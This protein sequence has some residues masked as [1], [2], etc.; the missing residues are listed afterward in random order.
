MVGYA[1]TIGTNTSVYYNSG[2][3][4]KAV[5]YVRYG[6]ESGISGKSS[7]ELKKKET[8]QGWDFDNIWG[9]FEDASYPYLKSNAPVIIIKDINDIAYTGTQIKPELIVQ[10][11]SGSTLTEGTHYTL[12][13]G[14]NKTVGKG[15]VTATGIGEFDGLSATK[16]FNIIPKTLT[17]ANAAAINKHYDGT[18]DAQITG[19]L[20]GIA[21]GDEVSFEVVS[22]AF[23]DKNTGSNK[24]V[25]A[26]I[27]LIGEDK[28]NYLLTQPANLKANIMLRV[29]TITLE[30]KTITMLNSETVPVLRDMLKYTGLVEGDVISGTT[31]I[32]HDYTESAGEYPIT[33]SGTRTN[34]NYYIT[35]DNED[36]LLVVVNE[37][38][39]SSSAP[40]PSSSS[41]SEDNSSSSV[42]VEHSS[43]SGE[44]ELSS[45]S[46]KDNPSSSSTSDGDNS[47]SSEVGDSSSSSA[48][49]ES[50]SSGF[51]EGD[52]SSSVGGEDSSSSGGDEKVLCKIGNLELEL[53]KEDCELAGGSTGEE[54]SSSSS[55][56]DSDSSSSVGGEDSSS[57][58][59]DE[60][61]SSSSAPEGNE[62]SSSDSEEGE[63]SSSIEDGNSSSSGEEGYSSS[64]KEGESSSSVEESDSSSSSEVG[65]GSSSSDGDDPSSS[66]GEGNTPIILPQVATAN[67]L[68]SI[69]NGLHL[70]ATNGAVV[71]LFNIRGTL[72][73]SQN[74][75]SGVYNI[76]LAHLPKGIYIAKV[77][78]GSEN[79]VIRTIIR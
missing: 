63:S 73:S 52:S 54:E 49:E 66:S 33:L 12:A 14:E 27:K 32:S 30:P 24:T 29:L 79:K 39:S 77:S 69:K 78:F 8:F 50:S 28:D 13:Y 25:T 42:G 58:S 26:N 23:A 61:S 62:S 22:A 71:K 46:S 4:S 59:E 76:P 44:H 19:T 45:S 68:V 1:Y 65:D 15:T 60:D 57:S 47:S 31:T 37:F 21:E 40:E 64:S 20:N 18:T 41:G 17:I 11:N 34:S 35:Y 2:G 3:A 43:S 5:G 6:S 51:D 53:S 74:Y 48:P 67:N 56:S 75:S 10:L 16:S 38:S 55:D 72:I 9:I 70:T 36:L 7:A